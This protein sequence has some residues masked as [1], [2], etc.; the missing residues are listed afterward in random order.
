[1]HRLCRSMAH[2]QAQLSRHMT[3]WQRKGE[4]HIVAAAGCCC[5]RELHAAACTWQ[6]CHASHLE[7]PLA[8]CCT[9]RQFDITELGPLYTDEKQ[10]PKRLP[11]KRPCFMRLRRTHSVLHSKTTVAFRLE[12]SATMPQH[13]TAALCSFCTSQGKSWTPRGGGGSSPPR[14]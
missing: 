7:T 2:A 5:Q 1:M 3:S 12:I 14:Q 8:S 6:P 10:Q 9:Y 13:L 4:H 11:H